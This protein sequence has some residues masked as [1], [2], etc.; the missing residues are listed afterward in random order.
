MEKSWRKHGQS[1]SFTGFSFIV[2][3]GG[4]DIFTCALV[5]RGVTK[6]KELLRCYKLFIVMVDLIGVVF[7]EQNLSFI[8]H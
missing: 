7:F 2:G 3:L 5:T 8:A 6:I 1:E 4:A